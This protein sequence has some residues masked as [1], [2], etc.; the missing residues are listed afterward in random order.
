MNVL[1]LV[2]TALPEA[3]QLMHEKTSP[4]G[5][6][7]A[8]ASLRL[9]EREGIRLSI[10]FPHNGLKKD[11]RLLRGTNVDYYAFPPVTRKDS[12]QNAVI[13]YLRSLLDAVKPDIVHVFG[14][15]F[16]HTLAMVN[17][18]NEQNIKTVISIQGLVSVI[19]Q[20]YLTGLPTTVQNRFTARDFIRQDNL[21]QQQRKFVN[22]GLL[23]IE[24]LRKVKHVIGRTTWD[25]ACTSQ[26]N[27]EA[28]YHF[29][30]ETLRD[31]FY[32][33]KWDI[34]KIEKQSIFI[35]QGYYPI[36]GLHY[37]LEAMPLILMRYPNAKLY[38]SGPNP[39]RS[40]YLLDRVKL[41]SYGKYIKQILRR[42]DIANNVIFTGILDEQQMCKRY[43]KS[44]LFVSPSMVENESNSLSEAKIM[45]VPCVASYV[46][47]VAG[48]IEHGQDGFYYQHDAPYMLAHYACE[49]FGNDELALHF[50]SRAREKGM[51]RHDAE[52]N[53]KTLLNIYNQ[54]CNQ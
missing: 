47:G 3:S 53:L 5:G 26:I 40:D 31:E 1:W 22:R 34:G 27:P 37:M 4:F 39:L 16:A 11:V 48:R 42:F 8:S 50:S 49:I 25:K 6:W 36:K 28:Q 45:G 33:H 20:H 54:I 52:A 32:Q 24:A 23:E 19:A 7:F 29:C 14:T 9:A 46:G 44:N 38:V 21:R 12:Q 15:E 18:C 10:S 30:N 43:L 35:S 41:D 13:K 2:N 17:A 51:L